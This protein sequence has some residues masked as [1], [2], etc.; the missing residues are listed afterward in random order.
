VK[1]LLAAIALLFSATVARADPVSDEIAYL[2][3][4]VRHS[5][6]TFIRNGT[7][8]TGNQAADH[9]QEKYNYY[10]DDIKTVED[11]IERAASKSILSGQPYQVRCAD[12][13]T[14]PAAD[15][16]RAEDTVYR[17]RLGATAN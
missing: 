17:A 16:I 15:W 8:Y 14:V 1:T 3:D 4:F 10:K 2:I 11:F 13:K 5:Q 9:V 6:C 12:G 7:E